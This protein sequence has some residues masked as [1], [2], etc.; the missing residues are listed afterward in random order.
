MTSEWWDDDVQLTA[1]LADALRDGRAVP[2]WFI[3]SAKA[4][5]AWHGIDAELA[6][7]T[8]DSTAAGASRE[9]LLRA[10]LAPLRALTFSATTVAIEV[11]VTGPA[12]VGQVVPEQRVELEIRTEDGYAQMVVVDAV[13]SFVIRPLPA[14]PFRLYCK[15]SSGHRILTDVITL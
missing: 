1:A 12:L 15:T 14:T 5:Y 7:L 13:G 9:L 6:T 10:E 8:H 2:E 11:E 3:T 4:A